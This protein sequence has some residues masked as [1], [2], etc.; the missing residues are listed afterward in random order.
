QTLYGKLWNSHAVAENARGQ[1]LLY[2]DRHLVQEVS[3]PQ[4]FASLDAKGREVRQPGTHLLVADHAIPTSQR[5]SPVADP[6]ARAQLQRLQENAQKYDLPYFH[7]TGED[8]GIVH[9][10]GP[11]LGFTLP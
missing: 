8:Q 11:E 4:A 7:Y 9:V 6:M 3:S 5:S 2:V 1:T 10:I